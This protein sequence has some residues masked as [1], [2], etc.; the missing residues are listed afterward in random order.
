MLLPAL[1]WCLENAQ[2]GLGWQCLI[3]AKIICFCK[4]HSLYFTLPLPPVTLN[5]AGLSKDVK[6]TLANEIDL[7]AFQNHK[8]IFTVLLEWEKHSSITIHQSLPL[9]QPL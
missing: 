1:S 5:E 7:N 2:A 4:P 8:V 3:P 9:R 6:N